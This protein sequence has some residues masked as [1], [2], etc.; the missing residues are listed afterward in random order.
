MATLAK[1]NCLVL[2]TIASSGVVNG[3]LATPSVGIGDA[4]RVRA[5]ILS[6]DAD[7]AGAGFDD[8]F[9]IFS[10][11]NHADAAEKKFG[12]EVG[13]EEQELLGD[14]AKGRVRQC[15]RGGWIDR[16]Y[17]RKLCGRAS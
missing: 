6:V 16:W 14:L 5:N 17:R 1:P 9:G 10:F 15:S 11:I 7:A 13:D 2:L 3:M 4:W 12:A 8:D